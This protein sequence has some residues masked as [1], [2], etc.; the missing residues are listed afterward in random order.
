MR[1]LP[2]LSLSSV[3]RWR[4]FL[5]GI[6]SRNFRTRKYEEAGKPLPASQLS[7]TLTLMPLLSSS[8]AKPKRSWGAVDGTADWT[9]LRRN[10]QVLHATRHH[11]MHSTPRER[12]P[13]AS[14]VPEAHTACFLRLLAQPTKR[15]LTLSYF[16]SVLI[17][18]R[19]G[20][21]ISSLQ[22]TSRTTRRSK[23]HSHLQIS[24][25]IESK[26]VTRTTIIQHPRG[27]R[28]HAIKGRKRAIQLSFAQLELSKLISILVPQDTGK[29][30]HTAGSTAEQNV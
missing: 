3:R 13:P 22:F 17:K 10:D 5:R 27:P 25:L 7:V 11:T 14:L 19:C 16:M 24:F 15:K 4:P 30:N 20:H 9:T 1:H 12:D 23:I 8:A 18:C 28:S 29:H 21:L 6:M 26:Y 2:V